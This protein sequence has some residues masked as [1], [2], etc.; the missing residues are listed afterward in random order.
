[1]LVHLVTT[2]T[3]AATLFHSVLGCC[4]HHDHTRSNVATESPSEHSGCCGG[5]GGTRSF[6]ADCGSDDSADA[7]DD[8]SQNVPEP[9]DHSHGGCAELGCVYVIADDGGSILN[10]VEWSAVIVPASIAQPSAVSSEKL[11]FL[12]DFSPPL[13]AAQELRAWLQVWTV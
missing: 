7:E 8:R 9:C 13:I 10:L 6:G 5:H 1:M 2:L 4:W 11:V 3:L 12:R